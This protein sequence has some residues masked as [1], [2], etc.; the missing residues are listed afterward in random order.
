M[1]TANEQGEKDTTSSR[2][3]EETTTFKVTRK[4]L[5]ECLNLVFK[6]G[7]LKSEAT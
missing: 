7:S 6:G 2:D 3:A 1:V 4:E 5:S